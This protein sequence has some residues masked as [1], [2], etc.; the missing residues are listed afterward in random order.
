M[1]LVY[2]NE[3]NCLELFP[4]VTTGLVLQTDKTS[5]FAYFDLGNIDDASIQIMEVVV[6]SCFIGDFVTVKEV[7]VL[8]ENEMRIRSSGIGLYY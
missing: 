2:F 8:V 4:L 1:D 6:I 3:S 7:F 5:S